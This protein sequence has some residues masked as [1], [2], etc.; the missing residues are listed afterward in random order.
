MRIK[1]ELTGTKNTFLPK[2]FNAC[3][4][5]VIYNFLDRL[6]AQW[7]HNNGY[8]YEKRS[9]KLFTFS[10]LL[11]KGRYLKREGLFV[12]PQQISF[13]ISSPVDWIIQQLAE[14]LTISEKV[15]LGEN[16]MR[17]SS[18]FFTV[19]GVITKRRTKLRA[20]SPVETHST[21]IKPDGRKVTHY[22]TPFEEEFSRLVN[23]NLKK[24]W[25]AFFNRPCTHDISIKPLFR[26]S[27]NE[28]IQYFGTGKNRTLIKGWKGTF[29]ATGDT[30]FLQFALET[31]LGSRNSNGFGMV[32]VAD[33]DNEKV[34]INLT[35]LKGS[36]STESADTNGGVE[37]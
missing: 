37:R 6:D 33:E 29:L 13:Y 22:Y 18:L 31:G 21:V 34:E 2:G 20:L 1:I 16:T 11:E 10:P 27:N 25:T 14:N 26:G 17:I 9:F 8:M 5:G 15:I 35:G 36:K 7:L 30:R 32:E 24:K 3:I 4:Q 19:P 23:E 12:F 28:R